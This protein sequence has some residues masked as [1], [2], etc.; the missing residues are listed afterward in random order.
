MDEK[1][2]FEK[3]ER[4]YLECGE[5]C[6]RVADL[7]EAFCAFLSIEPATAEE[8]TTA[9]KFH[10]IGKLGIP[11]EICCKPG[12]LTENEWHIMQ[13]HAQLSY[14]FLKGYGFS[15]SVCECVL[16][17]H[18]R[19]DGKGYCGHECGYKIP[20]GS[21][22]IALCDSY[23]AMT[24]QRCYHAPLAEGDALRDIADNAG[25]MYDPE[26]TERFLAFMGK[27]F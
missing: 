5:H 20:F 27:V 12:A 10:D 3:L 8:I 1:A 6:K 21:R 14:A 13:Q 9:A 2:I 17:H 16:H 18:E 22:V 11:A 15:N 25:K 4:D 7:V 19:W 24:S 23:D 26:L